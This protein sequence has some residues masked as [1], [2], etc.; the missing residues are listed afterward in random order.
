MAYPPLWGIGLAETVGEQV[1]YLHDGRARTLT[2]TI[3]WHWGEA[4]NSQTAFR[5]LSPTE[6]EALLA[7]LSSL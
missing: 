4:R 3:L 6:R 2:E 5:Q 1:N 7:F